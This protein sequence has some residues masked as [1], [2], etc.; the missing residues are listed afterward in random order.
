M[1]FECMAW[2]IRQTTGSIASKMILMHL[3]NC[4]NHQH[5]MCRPRIKVIAEECE[6]SESS[7]KRALKELADRGLLTVIPRFKEGV[8]LS[9]D[10]KLMM[11]EG[12]GFNLNPRGSNQGGVGSQGTQ[13]GSGGTPV[14]P[15]RP[16]G[17][18]EGKQ[19]ENQEGASLHSAGSR[20]VDEW[21]DAAKASGLAKIQEWTSKRDNKLKALIRV[22]KADFQQNASLAI[23]ECH[24]NDWCISNKANVDHLLVADNFQRYLDKAR[25]ATTEAKGG[26]TGQTTAKAA[27][28]RE[29]PVWA[30]NKRLQAEALRRKIADMKRSRRKPLAE[31]G[32][33][34]HEVYEIDREIR[35]METEILALGHEP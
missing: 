30:K 22:Y 5:G 4:T 27:D 29:E 26:Q 35:R 21:N 16:T 14:G 11:D 28:A 7:V 3:A 10:Y 8:Q 32:E 31:R 24:K 23:A 1:S 25:T 2:A 12:G 19:E 17:K 33:N 13:V 15:E 6:T 34:S 20:F 18:Q 9:S